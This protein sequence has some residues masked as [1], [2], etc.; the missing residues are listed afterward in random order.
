[1]TSR[2]RQDYVLKISGEKKHEHTETGKTY[3]FTERAYGNFARSFRLPEEADLEKIFASHK[4]GILTIKV[5]KL[6]PKKDKT[7]KIDVSRG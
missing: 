7:R 4:D 1:M 3:Y 5:A 2:Y 6:E